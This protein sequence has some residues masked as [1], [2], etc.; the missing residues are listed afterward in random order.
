MTL[1]RSHNELSEPR[2]HYS[3]STKYWK[4]VVLLRLSMHLNIKQE[5]Y[6]LCVFTMDY[7]RRIVRAIKRGKLDINPNQSLLS[8]LPT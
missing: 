2:M 1:I 8:V 6:P 7:M 4:L 3:N 5:D